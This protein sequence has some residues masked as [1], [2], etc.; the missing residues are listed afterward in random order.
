MD[1]NQ[2]TCDEIVAETQ[3]LCQCENCVR[4]VQFRYTGQACS[5]DF[6]AAGECA[7]T[8][9]N[10][11]VA[12]YRITGCDDAT[13]VFANGETEQGDMITIGAPDG[14]CLPA[15]M[16][17]VISQP[18]GAVTQT[19]KID[20]ACPSDGSGRGL[21]LQNSYGAFESIGYS[22]SETD[23]HNC[24][25]DV[26]YGLKVC[27]IGTTDEKIFEWEF[28]DQ[29]TQV[30]LLAGNPFVDADSGECLYD[31]YEAVVDRCVEFESCV[32][33]T[34]SATDP[35]TGLPAP[36]EDEHELKFGWE[37]PGT[38]PPTK[39]PTPPPTPA[40]SPSPTSTCIID[41]SLTGCPQYNSTLDNDCDGRPQVITFRYDGGD[42][43]ES[44]NLQPRQKFQCTDSNGGPSPSRQ[45]PYFITAV[46]TGG[47]DLYFS[48]SVG[49]GDKYTLNENKSF[50]K[51]SADMTISVFDTE[52]GTILQTN[53]IHLSCSQPLFV[54]DKFGAHQVVEWIETDGR[55]VSAAQSDVQTGTIEVKLDTGSE[56][57]KPVRLLEMTVITNTQ[58]EPIDYTSQVNGKVLNPGDVIELEG[59]GIDIELTERT[60]YTFFTTLI[61]ETL[62]GTNTCNGFDF[63][64][65][66]IGFNLNPVFPTD[67]PTPS[68]TVTP[69]PTVDPES[70]S[71][72]VAADV[73]CTV[74]S[75]TGVTCDQLKAPSTNSCPA[76]AELLVA[77]LKYDGSF[78]DNV[79]LEITCDKSTTYIDRFIEKDEVIRF[80][81]RANTD[82]CES[83]EFILYTSDPE[84]DG[85]FI[86]QT[87]VPLAC[88]GPWTLGATVANA[89]SIDALVDT[90][91]DG[92]TFDLHIEEATVQLDYVVANTGSFPLDVNTATVNGDALAFAGGSIAV[93]TRNQITLASTTETFTVSGQGGTVLAFPFTV[94]A[95]TANEFALPCFAETTQL[96]S[97]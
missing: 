31:T 17:V 68:P 72:D 1:G 5:P 56:V 85:D 60:R 15:C 87:T 73:L 22:C 45:E 39:A 50:D 58:D 11:F 76:D 82:V 40:P 79:F 49:V 55:V 28:F 71:C 23:T 77:F 8:A 86:E 16:N 63:L 43:S 7:D 95:Q 24:L 4:E 46:P 33:I 80:N 89:F 48:G 30:D 92:V 65:C 37:E 36:C 35:A 74:T 3:P 97:L 21:I 67:V 53:D 81:T 19:F 2:I 57:T 10:P 61:G 42:C 47:S 14:V 52:G 26:T 78:G 75:L 93:P 84:V 32:N 91:D 96:I 51:L 88:P 59:F 64:E 54:F 18:T 94:G 69:Y 34:A 9:P 12:G 29:K 66:T 44:N 25:E 41:I 83:V 62:D 13:Q 90:T 6:A 38:L 20:S 27:N 70:T